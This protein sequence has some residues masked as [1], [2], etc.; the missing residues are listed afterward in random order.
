MINRRDFLKLSGAGIAA[1][2]AATRAKSLLRARAYQ[3][4]GLSKFV[5]PLRGVFPLDSNGIPVAVP[6]GTR[7]WGR[8]VAQHYTIDINQ[9]TDQLHPNL[10]STTLR[11][12]HSRA[13][14]GGSVTQRHLGGIIVAHRGKPTQITFQNNL[15]RRSS[16]S[17]R[18]N[19]HGSRDGVRT[20]CRR[21]STAAKSP[22]LVMVVLLPG[23][24][25]PGTMAKA[26]R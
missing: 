15:D 2:F 19:R 23:L 13:N 1:L 8:A 4:S 26:F 21:T 11:G 22:G 17:S 18:P 10:G 3:S 14:L 6:D 5:Q 16:P 20:V 12:Y 9:Y 24:T 7:R 25:M